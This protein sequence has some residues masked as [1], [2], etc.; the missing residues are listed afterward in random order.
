MRVLDD[1]TYHLY[2]IFQPNQTR[3][4]QSGPV[5]WNLT[6]YRVHGYYGSHDQVG[7]SLFRTSMPY[8]FNLH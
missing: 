6:V 5:E 3:P 8:S 2:A 1:N 4:H 7:F